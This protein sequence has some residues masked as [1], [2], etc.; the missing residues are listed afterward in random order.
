MT[1][2]ISGRVRADFYS[3]TNARATTTLA[4]RQLAA[5][6]P[7]PPLPGWSQ[8]NQDHARQC[9]LQARARNR[10][11]IV[12]ISLNTKGRNSLLA[13]AAKNPGRDVFCAVRNSRKRR[14][15]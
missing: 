10:F 3:C 14:S 4:A 1:I 12:G 2:R 6:R 5:H 9:R 8:T 7:P 13:V 15:S 11:A